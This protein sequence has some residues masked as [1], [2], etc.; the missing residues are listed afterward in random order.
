MPQW[1]S[2]L[3]LTAAL[4]LPAAT[5]HAAGPGF[6]V[7]APDRGFLGNEEIRDQFDAFDQ[8]VPAQL[9]FVTDA[10]TADN[11]RT[12][13][14][15]LKDEG[16]D[17]IVILPLFVSRADARF[18]QL[19][20]AAAANT[21][22]A[23]R[24]ARPWGES[25][26]AVEALAQQL[27]ATGKG[28]LV[29]AGAGAHDAD[30]A[31][32]IAS[33][34]RRIAHA[35]IA[36]TGFTQVDIAVWPE[37]KAPDAD[38]LET[39]AQAVLTH[40]ANSTAI[41]FHLGK[42]LDGMMALSLAQER[43]LPEHAHWIAESPPGPLLLTWMQREA[44]RHQRWH[45]GANGDIGVIIAAHGSDWH[46]NDTMRQAVRPLA[47]RYRL[48]FAYSMADRPIVERAVR[49]LEAQGAKVIVIVR[50]FGLEDS[51][52]SSFLKM[53]GADV[54]QPYTTHTTTPGEHAHGHIAH[55]PTP[56]ASHDHGHGHATGTGRI[57]SSALI[58]TAGGLGDDRRFALALLDRARALST[59]PSRETIILTAHG[60]NN[61]ARNAEW[62]KVLDRIATH[63]RSAGADQFRNIRV[64]TWRED[65]PD[66]SAEWI[67]RVRTWVET[68][69][70]DGTAI[71]IPARTNGTGPEDKLLDGLDYRLGSGFAPHPL[72]AE[73]VES[74]VHQ[75]LDEARP[76]K[77]AT[78]T[79]THS[80]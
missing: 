60:T 41:P 43:S 9:V 30:G 24:S 56:A 34:L 67:P 38:T 68:A 6:L 72:F 73:W 54:E 64:A 29:L 57:P 37:H 5:A 23:T 1:I 66:K 61:D 20:Q 71:V 2:R 59:D 25:Y 13:V 58:L 69:A 55:T 40:A 79:A 17:E 15:A 33:D 48:A 16:A 42:R 50:V 8:H 19:Q 31:T 44:N 51:F 22:L 52:R 7:A 32:R 14:Q 11:Y 65:W 70:R 35:A 63:M 75:A 10:R 21:G 46:W 78:H 27:P 77:S 53:S 26:L 18:A 28:R 74:Q 39:K 45:D 80:H 49:R 36:G 4:A 12:A 3:I 47:A 62:L 76:N